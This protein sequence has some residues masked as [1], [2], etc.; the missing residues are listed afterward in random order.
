MS[1]YLKDFI[2]SFFEKKIKADE[3]AYCYMS[4]LRYE[5][6]SDPLSKDENH[7]SVLSSN[8]FCLAD[9]YN[10]D[11]NREEYEFNEDLLCDQIEI[12][13]LDD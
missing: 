1:I 3:F 8:I 4:K 9:M 2:D 6:D 5:R 13:M 7:L 10:P 11:A 12:L